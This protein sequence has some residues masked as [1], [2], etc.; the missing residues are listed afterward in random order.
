MWHHSS[1]LVKKL[2][3][4]LWLLLSIGVAMPGQAAPDA[5][6]RLL[7]AG[8]VVCEPALPVFCGNIH[9]TCAGPSSIKS[10]AFRLRA[11]GTQG[12]L[13]SHAD[14]GDVARPYANARVEWGEAA[15]YV[16]LWPQQ[17]NGYVKLL[18]DGSY[19]F[20]HYAPLGALMSRGEC[21]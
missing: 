21:R 8:E 10:F 20:R 14:D 2:L 9:V 1:P 15:A 18:A 13:E 5:I 6:S 11:A 17:G 19:S 3:R 16:I 4:T 12:A 7:Q